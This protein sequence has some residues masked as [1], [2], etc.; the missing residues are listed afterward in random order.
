MGAG[1]TFALLLT[2]MAVAVPTDAPAK[3]ISLD[4]R[5]R[6]VGEWR[7]HA[8][9]VRCI[10]RNAKR[11]LRL[12]AWITRSGGRRRI[13][14]AELRAAARARVAQADA[15]R[16][17][18]PE[19]LCDAER[20]CA[21]GETCD[22][23]GCDQPVGVCVPIPE[24]CPAD[25]TPRCTCGSEKDPFG[26]TY[27]N[28]CERIRAGAT[29]DSYGNRPYT[30][31][32]LSCGGPEGLTCPDG[33][34]CLYPDRTC[35]AYAEHGRC[36]AAPTDSGGATCGCDGVTYPT[37][38]SARQAGMRIA[39]DGACGSLCG[40]P[41]GLA[42]LA[43][44]HCMK[45]WGKCDD[46]HD[47]GQCRAVTERSCLDLGP[48]CGCDGQFYPRPCDAVFAGTDVAGLAVDGACPAP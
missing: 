27:T 32:E 23:R 41:T 10:K 29:L 40:G 43:G 35:G 20:S 34:V 42:C 30:S 33:L 12:E 7:D 38:A 6:C 28:E 47:W 48:V 36:S 44:E 22:I 3:I 15:S 31:C 11:Y 2:V 46:P 14:K 18:M 17:G 4:D 8:H 9:Y 26:R 21:A 24:V 37:R 19:Y 39:Y 25:I 45:E 13:P 1:R 16:C 5:C